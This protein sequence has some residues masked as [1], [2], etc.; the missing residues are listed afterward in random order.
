MLASIDGTS[1]E[2]MALTPHILAARHVSPPSI[3]GNNLAIQPKNRS[4]WPS[5][6]EVLIRM[7]GCFPEWMAKLPSTLR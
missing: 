2:Y 4:G 5:S 7:D 6:A 3:L 1:P